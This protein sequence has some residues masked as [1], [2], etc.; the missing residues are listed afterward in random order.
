MV[1]LKICCINSHD[2]AKTAISAGADL[3]GL[4]ADM[5]SGE[6]MIEDD[7]IRE[8][9]ASIKSFNNSVLLT[10]RTD[11]ESIIEHH[12]E[13]ITSHIQIVDYIDVKNYQEIRKSLPDIKLIQ[14]VHVEDESSYSLAMNFS[15]YVDFILLDSGKP[16][17]KKRTLGG[18]GDTH[19]WNI[20]KKIVRDCSI[21]VYLAGG[22]NHSNVVEAI[23]KVK[24]YGIDLCTGL[25]TNN[26]LDKNKLNAFMEAIKRA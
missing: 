23:Q 18:T 22:I 13:T 1:K 26:K 9:A 15:S 4:V 19:N 21:P 11:A 6:G 8:I 17:A 10:S 3:L 25:R 7:K 14:V 16:S 2:E 20:S 12:K 24:P 5:P